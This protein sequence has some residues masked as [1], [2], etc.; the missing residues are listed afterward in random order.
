MPSLNNQIELLGISKTAYY[1]KP[2]IL[3]SSN[4]DKKLLDAIDKIYTDFP[5]Y[6]TRRIVIELKNKGFKVCRNLIKKAYEYLSIKALYSNSKTTTIANRLDYKY[7]Y[8]LNEF[9]NNNRLVKIDKPN[10]VWSVD[11][12]YIK[13]K[14][15]FMSS[16]MVKYTKD[17]N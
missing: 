3:F 17:A 12:T 2:V 6:G 11:I 10:I 13:L 7:P 8:L 16:A 14:K 5:Y 4:K 9:K 15:G 1:Y